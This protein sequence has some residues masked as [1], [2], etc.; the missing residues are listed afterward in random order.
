MRRGLALIAVAACLLGG[1]AGSAGPAEFS[2]AEGD[3]ARA[4]DAVRDVLIARGF[5]LDRI[6]AQAGVITTRAKPTS[7]LATP[8]DGEQS[9]AGQE[10]EEFLNRTQRRARVTFD[11]AEG[12]QRRVVV[13]V[14]VERV[15]RRGWSPAPVSVRQSTF[16]H[17]PQGGAPVFASLVEADEALAARLSRRMAAH[18]AR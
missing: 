16:W 12:G 11:P 15:H 10:V 14:L 4:F 5:T 2:V 6:D 8:W 9:S 13:E 7:G 17:D 18:A 1:C 3:Y